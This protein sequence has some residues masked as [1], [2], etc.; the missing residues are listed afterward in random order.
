MS[1]EPL[2]LT[3]EQGVVVVFSD[4]WCAFGY[5]AVHRLHATRARLGLDQRVRFEH[6]AFP[7]ELLNGNPGSRPGSDSEVPTVGACAPEAGWQLWQSK[8][9]LY[10]SSSLPALEAVQA[11]R[12]QS[13]SAAEDLDL[14]LRRAFWAESRCISNQTVILEA[15]AR[16]STVDVDALRQA[17]TWGTARP[18]VAEQAAVAASDA[19]VC[20]PHL[21]LPDGTDI[22]NPGLDVEWVG[23]WGIGYP[24]I[25]ADD[26]SIYVT[27]LTS[28]ALP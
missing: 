22:P 19:V 1:D 23:D 13:A 10:P 5:L 8:D 28:S 4:I 24:L 20:S 21:F 25:K 2:S 9:W 18:Q 7:M 14:M 15:A 17:L 27:I 12:R 11:A 26:P 3:P 6:R 16:T